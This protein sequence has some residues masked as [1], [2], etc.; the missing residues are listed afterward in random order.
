MRILCILATLTLFCAYSLAQP[1]PVAGASIS[2]KVTDS[3]NGK[4]IFAAKVELIKDGKPFGDAIY[5]DENGKFSLELSNIPDGGYEVTVSK[6]NFQKALILDSELKAEGTS[7]TVDISLQKAMPIQV[8]EPA[9]DFM[10]T[11][12]TG[13]VVSVSSYKGKSVLVLCINN[14]FG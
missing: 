14:V 12:P 8:G 3:E 9:R 2:G 10:L 7:S 13:E 1:P 4:P 6:T 5:T 11:T